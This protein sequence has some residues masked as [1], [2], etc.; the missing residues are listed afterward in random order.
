MAITCAVST[1]RLVDILH[2]AALQGQTGLLL[3]QR[4]IEQQVEQ[5]EI[6]FENGDTVFARVEEETGEA[7]LSQMMNWKEVRISFHEGVVVSA[8]L[9]QRRHIERLPSSI[10][11]LLPIELQKTRLLRVLAKAPATTRESL[12]Q[13]P[14]S[15]IPAILP[16]PRSVSG[17]MSRLW[18][19]SVESVPSMAVRCIAPE[20]I[21]AQVASPAKVIYRVRPIVAA[22]QIIHRLDRRERL[23]FLLLDGKRS[24]REVSGLIH[25]S[26][27]EIARV[28]AHFLALGL[29]ERVE[30]DHANVSGA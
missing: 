10:N 20:P 17:S 26:E 13:T 27:G 21:F 25:R 2:Q 14:I 30:T 9:R 15:E 6:F 12:S 24:V 23:V 4:L 1:E 29:I 11:S 8:E 3:V 22:R 19:E 18:S 16:Q 5:G 7:A 28:L